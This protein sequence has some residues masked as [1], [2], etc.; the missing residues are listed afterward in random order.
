MS[1]ELDNLESSENKWKIFLDDIQRTTGSIVKSG[2]LIDTYSNHHDKNYIKFTNKSIE[3]CSW[4]DLIRTENYFKILI[5]YIKNKYIPSMIIYE[6]ACSNILY[7]NI[8]YAEILRRL[9]D[10]KKLLKFH[11]YIDGFEI[12]NFWHTT[13]NLLNNTLTTLF[14][15]FTSDKKSKLIQLNNEFNSLIVYLGNFFFTLCELSFYHRNHNLLSEHFK[16]YEKIFIND[17]SIPQRCDLENKKYLQYINAFY[18]LHNSFKE[19][20]LKNLF[21]KLFETKKDFASLDKHLLNF[22]NINLGHL[23]NQIRSNSINHITSSH[24]KA[25]L[26]LFVLISQVFK[27]NIHT[28]TLLLNFAEKADI[29]Y[30]IGNHVIYAPKFLFDHIPNFEYFVSPRLINRLLSNIANHKAIELNPQKERF[31]I[32]Q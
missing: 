23:L 11:I 24:F 27:P 9:F 28:A 30:R 26:G 19:D 17:Q 32:M 16:K 2:L 14:H 31:K 20:P 3:N 18:K 4:K 10:Y 21:S 25:H 29:V 12:R 1:I 8:S 15:L 22:M 6:K 5:I 13:F 7:D